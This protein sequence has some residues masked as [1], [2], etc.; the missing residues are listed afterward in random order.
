MFTV[1]LFFKHTLLIAFLLL[2][3]LPNPALLQGEAGSPQITERTHY[4]V[5][6]REANG[7][8]QAV[9]HR[10]V[11]LRTPLRSLD[12]A[13]WENQ[14]NT[15][16]RDSGAYGVALT[17]RSSGQIV[18]RAVAEIPAWVRGEF[19]KDGTLSA[20]ESNIDGHFFP[21]AKA[22]F[23]VRV[24]VIAGTDLDVRSGAGPIL[25]SLD[26]AAVVPLIQTEQSATSL[27]NVIPQSGD[28]GNRVDLLL[29]GDGY[30]AGQSANFTSDYNNFINNFFSITPYNEYRNYVNVTSLFTA[31]AESGADHPP[32]QASC[33]Q[34]DPYAPECCGDPDGIGDPLDGT[35]VSTAFDG[36]FCAFNT[37]RLLVVNSN[38]ILTAAAAV[39]D[40]DAILVIANDTTYG[41]SGGYI[42]VFSTHSLAVDIAQHEYGHSFTKLADEY[43]SPYP[44]FPACSDTDANQGNNCEAN[45]TNQTSRSLIKWTRWIAASTP[46]ITPGNPPYTDPD[47]VGLFLGARYFSA[48]MYRPGYACMMRYLSVPFCPVASEAY[49]LRLYN[50]GWG[51]PAG[52]ID[53]IEPGSESPLPGSTITLIAPDTANF[54][55]SLLGPQIGP[56]LDV[57]WYINGSEVASA[58][59][60]TSAAYTF[61]PTTSGT[62]T[63]KLEV[64]DVSSIIHPSIRSTIKTNR[65]WTLN[66]TVV[67]TP[68]LLSPSNG[69][70]FDN[71]LPTLSWTS[72]SGATSY[73]LQLDTVNP[74]VA[75]PLTIAGTSYTPTNFL[76][77]GTYY[78][79]VRTIQGAYQSEWSAVRSFTIASGTN[80]PPL[81]GFYTSANVPLTWNRVSGAIAYQIQVNNSATFNGSYNHLE[82]VNGAQLSTTVTLPQD[83]TYYWRVQARK[84]DGIWGGWSAGESFVVDIP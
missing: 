83:G 52:G 78:W 61:I 18:F 72:V 80:A 22:S 65:Q 62:F 4:I 26:P 57:R 64:M 55:A 82:E 54:S 36:T 24:P 48:G 13:E 53:N 49:A 30:T 21:L 75:T 67:A 27:V 17:Q 81:R 59:S 25:A 56:A 20:G 38:K 42:G 45:V 8:L 39:P 40:W 6:E 84:S 74:P 15:V 16:S 11:N 50:G 7:A 31:S 46:I 66:V 79:R 76:D 9:Y 73:E 23:V 2:I 63:L 10:Y 3:L 71:R 41:G 35:Y 34:T 33:S 68:G 37:H 29:M 12:S 1:K 32:Y 77:F 14:L 58:P 5:F 19:L 47:V 69:A 60:S 43:E 51:V 70:T 28:S 44:G